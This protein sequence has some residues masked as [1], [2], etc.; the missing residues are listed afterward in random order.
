MKKLL[1]LLIV[2]YLCVPVAAAEIPDPEQTGSITFLVDYNGEPLDGGSLEM[3]RVAEIFREGE[4]AW[5]VPVEE[6]AGLAPDL[7]DL[8]DPTLAE[9]FVQL[10]ELVEPEMRSAAIENG[11]AC[12]P[13]LQPG[14]YLVIQ[15][16]ENATEGYAALHPFLVSLPQWRGDHYVYDLTLESKVAPETLPTQPTEPSDPPPPTEPDLPQTG[17][18]NWPILPLGVTGFGLFV[19]GFYL[20]FGKR[21]RNET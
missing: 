13:D 5:Y 19:L 20:C 12:F 3:Y 1:C 17:Q 9:Q 21:D 6:L 2:L 7:G 10:L 16:P 15:H 18:L 11:K 14:V 4:G 8:S